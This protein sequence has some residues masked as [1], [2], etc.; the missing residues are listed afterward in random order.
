[1]TEA[2]LI[3]HERWPA[4]D[5]CCYDSCGGPITH[6]WRLEPWKKPVGGLC[7]RH[8]DLFLF[9][10]MPD[11]RDKLVVPLTAPNG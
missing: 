5:G 3:N 1:M 2:D 6:S 4:W 11:V 10:Y 8:A 9:Y 7:Q